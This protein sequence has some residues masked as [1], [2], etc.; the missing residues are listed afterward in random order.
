VK[1]V[2]VELWNGR[3]LPTLDMSIVSFLM[4]MAAISGNGG[5][6]NTP[7]SSYTRDQGWGMGQHVG[8]IPSVV[9][10]HAIEARRCRAG[11]AG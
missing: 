7:I 4:A 3:P 9:G 6:T 2:F 11:M 1:N 10:G 8:A 5:L